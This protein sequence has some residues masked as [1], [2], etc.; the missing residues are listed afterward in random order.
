[1]FRLHIDLPLGE[2]ESKAICAAQIAVD[3]LEYGLKETQQ[4]HSSPTVE[5]LK[6]FQYRLA[7]DNDRGIKNYLVKDANGHVTKNKL[8]VYLVEVDESNRIELEEK[9]SE[10]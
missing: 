3:A 6:M 9:K 10:V 8:K 1:M 4:S 2:D 7:S 5:E